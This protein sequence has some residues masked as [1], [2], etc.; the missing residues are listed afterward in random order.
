MPRETYDHLTDETRQTLGGNVKA[1]ASG[2]NKSD[3]HIYKI[4]GEEAAD[5]FALFESM[6]L[7]A[8]RGGVSTAEWDRKLAYLRETVQP[9]H[10]RQRPVTE[11]I[12]GKVGNEASTI[13]LLLE[14]ARD[15]RIDE[16][17]KPQIK[18]AVAAERKDLDE[19]D[20]LIDAQEAVH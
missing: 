10:R 4:L 1:M 2:W 16:T 15:G 20:R 7:G 11:I 14:A 6:Y 3:R 13:Q 9:S 18:K 8:L 5:G 17:E 12:A 19:I